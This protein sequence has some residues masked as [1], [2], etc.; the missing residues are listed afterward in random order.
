MGTVR[1]RPHPSPTTP[2]G[3]PLRWAVICM[4]AAGGGLVGYLFGGPIAAVITTVAVATAAHQLL[5]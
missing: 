4:L 2:A 3:L 1:R 5:A